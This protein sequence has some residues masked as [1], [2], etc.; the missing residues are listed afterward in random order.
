MKR[1]IDTYDQIAMAEI[2]LYAIFLIGG[3]YLMTK[4]GWRSGSYWRY[5]VVF[6]LARLIG[7]GMRV[8]SIN[9]ATN[10]DLYIGWLTTNSVALGPLVLILLGLSSRLFDS[11]NRQGHVVV[12]PIFQRLIELLMLVAMILSI[13][14]GADADYEL[15]G[16][17]QPKV[18][19]PTLSRVGM[20]LMIVVLVL[21]II[22]FF[23][24]FKKQ[25][26]VS[27][28]EHRIFI[29]IGIS[30]PFVAVR[31]I[32][33][34]IRIYG[35]TGRSVWLY[36][37]M[38]VIMELVVVSICEAVGFSLEKAAP[39]PKNQDQE[40]QHQG[41]KHEPLVDSGPTQQTGRSSR[42]RSSKGRMPIRGP[43][44]MLIHY[45]RKE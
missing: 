5:V 21:V 38:S 39:M 33:S 4:H 29:A 11:I 6:S 24:L 25:G 44:G 8:A 23:M 42:G 32:Y 28:G 1:A 10:V 30:I 16:S 34:S 9:D 43:I 35:G 2:V 26:L 14:G 3:I 22:Q 45:M 19:Y 27:Q 40:M 37:G 7:S 17:G 13:V 15:G 36:L 20:A 31:L 41:H 12:K 18:K